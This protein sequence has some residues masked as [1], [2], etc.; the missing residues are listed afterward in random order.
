MNEAPL[1]TLSVEWGMWQQQHSTMAALRNKVCS[2]PCLAESCTVRQWTHYL[3]MMYSWLMT[4]RF[5]HF[6][7]H[8]ALV[9]GKELNMH[10]VLRPQ[11]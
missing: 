11:R 8:G 1:S 3:S 9:T 5:A 4:L 10:V 6:C 2:E 7:I